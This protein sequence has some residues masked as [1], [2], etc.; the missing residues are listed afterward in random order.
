MSERSQL[1]GTYEYSLIIKIRR[2][3]FPEVSSLVPHNGE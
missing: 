2:P 3:L 1:Y